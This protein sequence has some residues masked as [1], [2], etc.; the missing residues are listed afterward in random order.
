MYAVVRPE[1]RDEFGG[2]Q[3]NQGGL[4]DGGRNQ[5]EYAVA[6]VLVVALGPRDV[7]LVECLPED[8]VKTA[9]HDQLMG[10]SSSAVAEPFHV[11]DHDRAMYGW[12]DR[13]LLDGARTGR[14]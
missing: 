10:V 11:Y 14:R 4:G 7:G 6:A 5:Y 3:R 1:R 12:A 8:L 2:Q 13:R 9:P